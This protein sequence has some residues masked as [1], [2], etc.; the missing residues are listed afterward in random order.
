[1]A[2]FKGTSHIH[3]GVTGLLQTV[4]RAEYWAVILALQAFSGIQIGVDNLNVCG[5]VA[6]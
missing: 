1:M 3:A 4:L 6:E 5:G 2:T